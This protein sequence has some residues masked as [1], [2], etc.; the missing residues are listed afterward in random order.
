MQPGDTVYQCRF[1]NASLAVERPVPVADLP[2]PAPPF[3]D[4]EPAPFHPPQVAHPRV[5]LPRSRSTNAGCVVGIVGIATV[6]GIGAIVA[7]TS[8]VFSSWN[9][10]KPLV[11][12]GNDRVV[13]NNV[14]AKFSKGAAIDASG[15]CWVVCK[16]CKLSAPT[17]IRAREN[18]SVHL[19]HG[20]ADGSAFYETTEN[21]DVSIDHT[22]VTGTKNEPSNSS[23]DGKPQWPTTGPFVCGKANG[24]GEWSGVSVKVTTGAAVIGSVNC[25]VKLSHCTIEGPVGLLLNDNADVELDDCQVHATDAVIA[26]ANGSVVLEGGTFIGKDHAARL[27]DNATLR[28]HGTHV[29]GKTS[30]AGNAT[31]ETE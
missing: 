16:D 23:T 5:S 27:E 13:V 20:S 12:A 4:F 8:G 6:V 19:D 2:P 29:E 22:K 11:C 21:A 24:G 15:N 25:H 28:G 30:T 3:V 7:V 9:G 17:V 14:T 26:R 31:A 1:C 18:A 10:D